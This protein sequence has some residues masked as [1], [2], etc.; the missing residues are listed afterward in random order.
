MKSQ[1]MYK[2]EDFV[3]KVMTERPATRSDDFLLVAEVCGEVSPALADPLY[4]PS[5]R[6]VMENHTFWGL[7]SFETITRIRRKLQ[8]TE[9]ELKAI[10]EVEEFRFNQQQEYE[11]YG[12]D[13]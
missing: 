13:K 4:A 3:R 9:P 6:D 11:R 12:L 7:P 1:E 5:F 2:V 8:E 10:E